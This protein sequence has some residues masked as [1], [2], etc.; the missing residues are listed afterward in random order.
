AGQHGLG[1][2]RGGPQRVRTRRALSHAVVARPAQ[3]QA[4]GRVLRHQGQREWPAWGGVAG[5]EAAEPRGPVP[6]EVDVKASARGT[7]AP[8]EQM[9]ERLAPYPPLL[10]PERHDP[11]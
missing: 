5:G 2:A 7:G 10:E 9:L 6:L 8:D 11:P 3:V 1:V 4:R